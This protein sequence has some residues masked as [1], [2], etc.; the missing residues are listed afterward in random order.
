MVDKIDLSAMDARK[1]KNSNQAFTFRGTKAL[2][3]PGQLRL[4]LTGKGIVIQGN[5]GGTLA[6]EYEILLK[7]LTS[8]S[9]IT[10]KDFKL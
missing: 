1:S 3:G 9:D 7:G 6:P 2:N 5:T 4:K 10:A 8:T